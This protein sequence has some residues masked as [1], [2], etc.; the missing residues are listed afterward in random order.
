MVRPGLDMTPSASRTRYSPC[1]P[2]DSLSLLDAGL[3]CRKRRRRWCWDDK[4][5]AASVLRRH[6]PLGAGALFGHR[7]Q[8]DRDW[9]MSPPNHVPYNDLRLVMCTGGVL[10]AGIPSLEQCFARKRL[11]LYMFYAFPFLSGV[12]GLEVYIHAISTKQ[13]GTGGISTKR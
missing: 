9:I 1:R 4:G 5:P 6:I 3:A 13:S 10:V 7:A 12:D 2:A 11:Y 8:P